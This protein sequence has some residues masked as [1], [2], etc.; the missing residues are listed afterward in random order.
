LTATLMERR[1]DGGHLS[2]GLHS[3]SSR[4]QRLVEQ[5]MDMSQMHSGLLKFN[6]QAIDLAAI[7]RQ[8]VDESRLAHPGVTFNCVVPRQMK[9]S[10]DADRLGQVVSNLLGNASHYGTRDEPVLLQ[11][12][13]ERGEAVLEVSNVSQAIAQDVAATLFRPFKRIATRSATNRNGLGLGLYIAEQIVTGHHGQLSYA[14]AEPYV[15]F[16]VR[17]PLAIPPGQAD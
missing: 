3:S 4:M 14:Y 1:G 5:V 10:G 8:L 17:L 16:S 12:H 15:T 9:L 2:R 7:V 13:E 11:L 6:M